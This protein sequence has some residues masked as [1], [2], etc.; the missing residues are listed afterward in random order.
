MHGEIILKWIWIT[1]SMSVNWTEATRNRFVCRRTS[2]SVWVCSLTTVSSSRWPLFRL[3]SYR[4]V[5]MLHFLQMQLRY[6]PSYQGLFIIQYRYPV[7][8]DSLP[9]SRCTVLNRIFKAKFMYMPNQAP[10]HTM[11]GEWR[12]DSMHS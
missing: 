5:T 4:L 1:Y 7:W 10:H 8:T 2:G 9:S 6:T 3:V 12:D 11:Y